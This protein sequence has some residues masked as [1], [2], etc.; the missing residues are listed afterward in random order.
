MNDEKDS[1]SVIKFPNFSGAT[2][3][4][5]IALGALVL[6]LLFIFAKRQIMRFTLRSRRGPH[7]PIG[8]SAPKGLRKEIERRLD[9][10]SRIKLEPKLVP[11]HELMVLP[12]EGFSPETL[13][14]MFAIDEIKILESQLKLA[15]D[16]KVFRMPG[17][18]I[19][20]FLMSQ[21]IGLLKGAQPK[22]I[23]HLCDLYDRARYSPDGFSPHHLQA[24]RELIANLIQVIQSN[25]VQQASPKMVSKCKKKELSIQATSV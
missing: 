2:I 23:H 8:H 1:D 3:V 21:T 4:I 5:F 17:E 16:S 12:S 19:R 10:I 20:T 24:Y 22:C 11:E 15:S 13:G 9:L 7:V 25:N 14:R 18:N 6:V